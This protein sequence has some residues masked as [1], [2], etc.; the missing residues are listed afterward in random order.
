MA[1]S[2][3]DKADA[4]GMEHF[5]ESATRAV[6]RALETSGLNPQPLP[7]APGTEGGDGGGEAAAPLNPQPL[8]PF[9]ITVGLIL[10]MGNET[11]VPRSASKF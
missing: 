9:D 8:P 10:S 11:A 1:S 5:I 3:F 4:I 6:L 7:P 2:K